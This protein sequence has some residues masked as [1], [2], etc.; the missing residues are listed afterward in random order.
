M[1][2]SPGGGSHARLA[3]ARFPGALPPVTDQAVRGTC[4]A[5]AVAG[6][7]ACYEG[8]RRRVSV[9]YLD[10]V[11]RL[12]EQEWVAR[13]LKL[14]TGGEPPERD[15]EAAFPEAVSQAALLVRANGA[16]SDGASA[17]VRALGAKIRARVEADAGCRLKRCFEA[18]EEY[19]ACR[20]ELWPYSPVAFNAGA[21]GGDAVG[22]FPPGTHEDARRHRIVNGLYVLRAP[23]NVDEIKGILAGAQER[24]PMPVCVG[25][26]LFEGRTD[27]VFAMPDV[28]REGDRV[29]AV[30]RPTGIH[31]VL[32]V[33]FQNDAK[34]PGGGWFTFQNSWG[35]NWGEAGMGRVSYAYVAC[36]CREAGTI[37]QEPDEYGPG[38][39]AQPKDASIVV[40]RRRLT[41]IVAVSVCLLAAAISVGFALWSQR[42]PTLPPPPFG[43]PPDIGRMVEYRYLMRGTC[44]TADAARAM[45][46]TL[47]G[48]H[49][50]FAFENVKVSETNGCF[51]GDMTIGGL[52]GLPPHAIQVIEEWLKREN[53]DC[54]VKKWSVQRL[55]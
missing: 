15:F 55:R 32:I 1:R 41:L 48:R 40:A 25:L 30:Q 53:R 24:R 19:G 28:V 23:N 11:T 47:E 44:E 5:N 37:L 29:F 21:A 39:A 38:P 14:L 52:P 3:R 27:G 13:N 8:C 45:A 43:R 35:R 18:L 9:Q 4:V 6:L 10:E 2:P 20:E 50:A 34:A 12:V 54:S 26:E 36:F 17:F 22:T 16:G 51:E 7:V 33:G 49:G 31:E 46:R 42:T